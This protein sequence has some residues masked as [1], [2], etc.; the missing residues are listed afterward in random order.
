LFI[1]AICSVGPSALFAPQKTRVED[2]Y[3]IGNSK[4][5]DY[6]TELRKITP[7]KWKDLPHVALAN[8]QAYDEQGNLISGAAS[9]LRIDTKAAEKFVR[10]YGGFK[11]AISVGQAHSAIF[12]QEISQMAKYQEILRRVWT[13]KGHGASINSQNPDPSSLLMIQSDLEVQGLRL[14]LG[15]EQVRDVVSHSGVAS[16]D[17]D[18][19]HVQAELGWKWLASNSFLVTMFSGEQHDQIYLETGDLWKL[20]SYLFLCDFAAKKVGYC[21]NPDCAAPYYLKKRKDQKFC[22]GAAR[23]ETGATSSADESPDSGS[24]TA[25]AQRQYA[26]NW[27][28]EKRQKRVK[29]Q[30]K[31]PR[32]KTK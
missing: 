20:I 2:D 19:F 5:S 16:A 12:K 26:K 10:T 6:E 3:V 22:T 28:R 24:C 29:K 30:I 8:L 9:G 11:E 7:D 4:P 18:L 15:L 27:W 32:R 17:W 21:G 25:Y 13:F 1:K 31:S 14:G 23:A